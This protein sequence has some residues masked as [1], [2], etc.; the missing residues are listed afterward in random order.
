MVWMKYRYDIYLTSS[1]NALCINEISQLFF[2]LFLIIFIG[3]HTETPKKEKEKKERVYN[4]YIDIYTDIIYK[5]ISIV[6]YIT[7]MVLKSLSERLIGKKMVM[8]SFSASP[9]RTLV[10]YKRKRVPTIKMGQTPPLPSHQASH[11][12]KWGKLTL[13]KCVLQEKK[14]T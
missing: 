3:I 10:N 9:Q 12:Q 4:W 13:S 6:I 1:V 11:Y 2:F 7:S 14:N 8:W 5:T